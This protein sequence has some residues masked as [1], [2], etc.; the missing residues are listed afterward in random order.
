MIVRASVRKLAACSALAVPTLVLSAGEARAAS[1]DV[2]AEAGAVHRGADDPY[3]MKSGLGWGG[4]AE[5]V[6]LPFVQVGPYYLHYELS[7]ADGS[8]RAASNQFDALGARVRLTLPLPGIDLRPYAFA[9]IGY[10]W[11]TYPAV[12]LPFEASRP[13]TRTGGYADVDGHFVEVPLGVGLAW[14]VA[15][16]F[17]LSADFALRPGSSFGGSAYEGSGAVTLPKPTSGWSLLLG[18]ALRL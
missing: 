13:S 15:K 11:L 3:A 4:H 6:L 8:S 9:G 12:A 1:I 10:T 17:A 14:D 18:A 7:P 2:G 16:V 5:L